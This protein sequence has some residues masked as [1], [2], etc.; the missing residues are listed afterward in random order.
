MD[1]EWRKKNPAAAPND[2]E[3]SPKWAECEDGKREKG[4]PFPLLGFEAEAQ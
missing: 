1:E 3:T 4:E 2:E